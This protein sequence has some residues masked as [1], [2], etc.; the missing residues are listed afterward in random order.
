MT[1]L[2]PRIEATAYER[3]G[4]KENKVLRIK[5]YTWST[6][7]FDNAREHS[8]VNIIDDDMVMLYDESGSVYV[9]EGHCHVSESSYRSN[10]MLFT[11]EK[12]ASA[13]SRLSDAGVI[14]GLK[15]ADEKKVRDDGTR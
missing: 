11:R 3:L 9:G 13:V 14:E 7:N 6:I 8:M 4:S 10:P 1:T 15:V 5:E 12:C 2:S